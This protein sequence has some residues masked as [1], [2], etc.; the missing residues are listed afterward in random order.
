KARNISPADVVN[1]IASQNLILPAGTQKI[2]GYEY[3]VDLNASPKRGAE[4]N[5]LPI[6]VSG[7]PPIYI[8]DVAHVRDG[9]PPQTNIVRVNGQRAV[10]LTI[11]KVGNTSTLDIISRV[12]SLLPPIQAGLPQ[13]LEVHAIGDQSLF[14]RASINGVL[15]E[16]I[17]AACLTALMI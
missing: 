17:V 13:G 8:R 6:K 7:K 2:G 10:L 5:D 12:K 15:R 16:A 4:L 1:A 3:D 11:Q 9:F 14:V